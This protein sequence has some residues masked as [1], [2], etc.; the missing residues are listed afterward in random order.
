MKE[1]K[2]V[3]EVRKHRLKIEKSLGNDSVKIL[4]HFKKVQDEYKDRLYTG[5]P[6]L[7]RTIKVA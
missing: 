4:N 1:D 3:A 6:K 5:K 2:I 7:L